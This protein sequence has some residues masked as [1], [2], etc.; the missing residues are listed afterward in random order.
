MASIW[1]DG[2]GWCQAISAR[3]RR[4]PCQEFSSTEEKSHSGDSFSRPSSIFWKRV[5][6]ISSEKEVGSERIILAT[7]LA[8]VY[9]TIVSLSD[10]EERS[11]S[12]ISSNVS[13]I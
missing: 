8:A 12:R 1:F 9:L 5:E 7:A 10:K 6:M 13:G 4:Q 3:Q 2:R 11:Q